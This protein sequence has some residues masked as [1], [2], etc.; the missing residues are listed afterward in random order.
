MTKPTILL[1]PAGDLRCSNTDAASLPTT[2]MSAPDPWG[3]VRYYVFVAKLNKMYDLRS[4]DILSVNAVE[5]LHQHDV[6]GREIIKDAL[7]EGPTA[8]ERVHALEFAPGRDRFI[9]ENGRRLLNLWT[10]GRVQ[11][12]EGDVRPFLDHLALIFD[13]NEEAASYFL[14]YLA[15]LAQHPGRK[16]RAALVITGRQGTGKSILAKIARKI[17]GEQNA[18]TLSPLEVASQ[19]NSW[20]ERSMMTVIEEM[21]LDDRKGTAARLKSWIT[22]DYLLINRKGVAQ[23]KIQNH[24]HFIIL[25][26]EENPLKL[27][28]D[29]RRYFVWNSQAS[30]RGTGYYTALNSWLDEDGYS[31]ILNFLLSFDLTNFNPFR[32]PP[33]TQG[34]AELIRHGMPDAEVWL[35]E[36]F[37][38]SEAPFDRELV[39]IDDV[40]QFLT[41][42]VGIR[43][44]LKLVTRV[45]KDLGACS[46]GQKRIG[47]RKL[48]IWALRDGDRWSDV[49]ESEIAAEYRGITANVTPP[50]VR[51]PAGSPVRRQVTMSANTRSNSGSSDEIDAA[52]SPSDAPSSNCGG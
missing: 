34:R 31:K 23:Y 15:H 13:G 44:S 18:N 51:T 14:S 49:S 9:E 50:P 17:V 42:G 11:P 1:A 12:I 37:E 32:A 48:R 5:R 43:A 45:L 7:L 6:G 2:G 8:V 28:Q 41:R 30:P 19:F 40:H 20:I 26:N 22:D 38:A 35:R 3:F 24:T 21:T 46:L 16:I 47:S 36:A 29:D 33:H 4:G 52:L 27:D 25:S 10:P 39:V